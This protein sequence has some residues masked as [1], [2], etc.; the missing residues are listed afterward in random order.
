MEIRWEDFQRQAG[1]AFAAVTKCLGE[2][3]IVI[4]NAGH[5]AAALAR[6]PADTPMIIAGT[7][8][9]D[10]SLR[11]DADRHVV[12][13]AEVVPIA[14]PDTTVVDEMGDDYPAFTP[15]LQ[16]GAVVMSRNAGGPPLVTVPQPAQQR[17]EEA[18]AG[19]EVVEA[20]AA[21]VELLTWI[22]GTLSTLAEEVVLDL[23]DEVALEHIEDAD[24][25]VALTLEAERLRQA[26]HRLEALHAQVVE[27][28][29]V[30][31]VVEEAEGIVE[32]T[33]CANPDDSESA[34]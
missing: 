5:L 27:Y 6:L 12:T 7:T 25:R 28:E 15:A 33:T 16:L 19:G 14:V 24:I 29:A 11:Q 13:L 31:D 18:L 34:S 3:Q 8:R 2:R 23:D 20:L 22:A 10:P 1:E 32:L 17:A 4:H 26:A 30:A 21:Q 9:I